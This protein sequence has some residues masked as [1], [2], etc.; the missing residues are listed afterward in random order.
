MELKAK[1]SRAINGSLKVRVGIYLE[2]LVTL[3]PIQY[4]VCWNGKRTVIHWGLYSSGKG[5]DP[6]VIAPDVMS[7]TGYVQIP[8]LIKEKL[9]LWGYPQGLWGRINPDNMGG[10]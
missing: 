7:T 2:D 4:R 3:S 10:L 8:L 1:S 6:W 9:H 5:R